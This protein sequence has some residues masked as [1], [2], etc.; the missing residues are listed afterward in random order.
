[1]APSV[2]YRLRR[3]AGVSRRFA[4][5]FSFGSVAAVDGVFAVRNRHR[6]GKAR[7]TLRL[8]GVFDTETD[9]HGWVRGKVK[10]RGKGRRHAVTCAL[11]K[12]AWS[13]SLAWADDDGDDEF[14]DGDSFDEGDDEFGD[15]EGEFDEDEGDPGDDDDV[16][17]DEGP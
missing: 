8:R 2:D 3:C 1:M 11:P 12:L 5:K 7:V 17:P 10:F 13:T 6:H 4:E 15:D 16:D 14:G 9:A